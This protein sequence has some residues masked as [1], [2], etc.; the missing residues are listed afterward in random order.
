MKYPGDDYITQ[1]LHVSLTREQF[2]NIAEIDH[3]V[4]DLKRT[5]WIFEAEKK[6]HYQ[7]SKDLSDEQSATSKSLLGLTTVEFN[8]TDLCNRKCWMC[9]HHNEEL[10][11]NNNVFMDLETVKN[12]VD[13]LKKNDYV[14]TIIFGSYG[15][16]LLHP[17]ILEMIEYVSNNL[18]NCESNLITNGD[19]FVK[20]SIPGYGLFDAERLKNTGLTSILIDCYD[21]DER[22]AKYVKEIKPLI[23]VIDI[24]FYRR[25]Y[26]TPVYLDRAGLMDPYT[27]KRPTVK[28][29]NSV[30]CWYPLSKAF[31]DYDGSIRACCHNW[32]RNL[33]SF[34]NVNDTD[35]S[36]LWMNS[37]SFNKLR[38]SLIVNRKDSNEIC[39]HCSAA[40]LS[41]QKR[42]QKV[43]KLWK[44]VLEKINKL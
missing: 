10:F 36:E 40:G 14:G 7:L 4:I 12:T 21:D 20:G 16:P 2:V 25:Y 17:K 26:K 43:A 22:L 8:V 30:P 33:G 19:R 23:G 39:K 6:F 27:G 41:S 35:F 24:E 1:Q 29:I 11:P 37:E 5:H 34:G 13:N 42:G 15:E 9:P 3:P 44:P 38:K 32:E 31:I 18:P 28:R